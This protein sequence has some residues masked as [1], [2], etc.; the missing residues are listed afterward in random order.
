MQRSCKVLQIH[1]HH[2]SQASRSCY[3][4]IFQCNKLCSS[5]DLYGATPHRHPIVARNF[6][7]NSHLVMACSHEA[8]LPGTQAHR[9]LTTAQK[10]RLL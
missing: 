6:Y 2:P 10:P 9:H 8:S 3:D 1:R 4:A 7:C 5:A